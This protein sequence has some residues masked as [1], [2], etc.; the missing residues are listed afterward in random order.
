MRPGCLP[1]AGEKT[2]SFYVEKSLDGSA[3]ERRARGRIE[4]QL[5]MTVLCGPFLCSTDPC[6]VV[7]IVVNSL[8]FFQFQWFFCM[9]YVQS[10]CFLC[11]V[12]EVA[13][14][15]DYY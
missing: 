10:H 4:Q 1:Q 11:T 5:F 15:L 6:F 14:R 12:M 7:Q 3:F 2:D 9:K 13:V 8:P